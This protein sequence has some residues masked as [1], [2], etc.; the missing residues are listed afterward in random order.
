MHSSTDQP[1]PDQYLWRSG[2]LI[3]NFRRPDQKKLTIV[4]GGGGEMPCEVGLVKGDLRFLKQYTLR[5]AELIGQRLGIKRKRRDG[6]LPRWRG[7]DLFN[8]SLNARHLKFMVK[9]K[10]RREM[11]FRIDQWQAAPP[12]RYHLF[13]AAVVLFSR[14]WHVLYWSR[15]A[16]CGY[17]QANGLGLSCDEPRV[18]G[19]RAICDCQLW[20]SGEDV[21]RI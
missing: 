18:P 12:G 4:Q 17:A 11:I 8:K 16:G 15:S 13:Q 21:M 10:K 5:D 20:K 6:N 19:G 2:K 3:S 9:I 7:Y 14:A 1:R